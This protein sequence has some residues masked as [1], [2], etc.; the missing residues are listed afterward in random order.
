MIISFLT[1]LLIVLTT[2]SAFAAMELPPILSTPEQIQEFAKRIRTLVPE[3]VTS[4]SHRIDT[5]SGNNAGVYA[6]VQREQ[7]LVQL[8]RADAKYMQLANQRPPLQNFV[9][10]KVKVTVEE[11]R[12]LSPA[13][14]AL[15]KAIAQNTEDDLDAELE[16]LAA[17]STTSLF[18]GL[19]RVIPVE[20]R[21]ALKNP[22]VL[23]RWRA[24]QP[25][26]A[27]IP[28]AELRE[29]FDVQRFGQ[30][31][32][33]W[34]L[35]DLET[36]VS[37]L[38]SLEEHLAVEMQRLYESSAGPFS[39]A[40][41]E[42]ENPRDFIE[43]VLSTASVKA[44]NAVEML[45]RRMAKIYLSEI[46]SVPH[47]K[48]ERTLVLK[49]LPPYL[50]IYRGCVGQ[51]CSTTASWAF[52]YSPY[53]RDWF[54]ENEKGVRLGYV[55]GN[56]TMVDGRHSLYIRD[57]HGNG[58]IAEDLVMILDCFFL[59]K[60]SYGVDQMTLAPLT[61]AGQNHVPALRSA[62]T[63]Y[64][65]RSTVNQI[66]EDEWI[67]IKYL[68]NQPGSGL[69]YD[70][71]AA[72][73]SARL[74]QPDPAEL[75]NYR[76]ESLPVDGVAPEK[77][78]FW[79]Q[80]DF[81]VT[82]GDANLMAGLPAPEGV[83]WAALIER[84]RNVDQLPIQEYRLAVE[85]V[86]ARADLK[87]SQNLRRKYESMF[88]VGH[89]A[90]PDAFV[91][92]TAQKQSVRYVEDL[93]WRSPNPIEAARFIEAH[94]EV[95]EENPGFTRQVQGLFERAQPADVERVKILWGAGYRFRHVRLKGNQNS[96][97]LRAVN[98]PE[99]ILATYAHVAESP[100]S[101]TSLAL[102]NDLLPLAEL[103][104][105]GDGHEEVIAER[106]AELLWHFRRPLDQAGVLGQVK[107]SINDEDNLRIRFP[108]AAL[109]LRE[110]ISQG[111]TPLRAYRILNKY[112]E[113]ENISNE[114]RLKAHQ[115]LENLPAEFAA[116]L[117]TKSEEHDRAKAPQPAPEPVAC[118]QA[119]TQTVQRPR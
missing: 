59:A 17:H 64:K 114:W 50:A 100:E 83:P 90:A 48:T 88:R 31:P 87:F 60:A 40:W 76:I 70:S 55:S 107:D 81:A 58:M 52:P 38:N 93:L 19:S 41:F 51:D 34:T 85:E 91:E 26:L 16:E 33:D 54:V 42:E 104:Q 8:L 117:R 13:W 73:A 97:L 11:G 27:K 95:F 65:T 30:A 6:Y 21:P 43:R 80:L 99:L 56:I 116:V 5:G 82:A 37:K 20:S 45:G 68:G 103:L 61:F 66:F 102:S 18:S 118:E 77:V 57:I 1:R 115:V 22:N 2:Q 10:K 109:Y 89:L 67:R 47:E 9:F 63:A 94:L 106:A 75:V 71:S 96:W 74:V 14:S 25:I 78:D 39:A 101:E 7:L 108:L 110:G 105:N 23:E 86:F 112:M 24:V 49:E 28:I 79:N 35:A 53:E 119:L 46:A 98:D 62:V 72:H 12:V 111:E 3:T 32:S 36:I 69:S 15:R 113:S 84:I 92:P 29:R 4:P 44:I